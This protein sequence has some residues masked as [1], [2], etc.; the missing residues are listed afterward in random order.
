[1]ADRQRPGLLTL[2]L[3]ILLVGA[4]AYAGAFVGLS[5]NQGAFIYNPDRARTAPAAANL[6][7]FQAVE[8]RTP[9]GERLVGWWKPPSRPEEGV[10]LYLH[11]KGGHL[12]DRATRLRD[13]GTEGFGVLGVDWRGYGGSTG[14]PSEAGLNTDSLAAYD[15]IRGRL[16]GAKIAVFAESL[17]TGPAVTLATRRPVAGVVLDSA[18]ASILRLANWRLPIFPNSFL[19]TDVYRSEDRIAHIN[20]PLLMTHCDGDQTIPIAEARRLFAA[21]RPP[22]EM[23]VLKGC[24]HVQTWR[25]LPFRSKLNMRLHSWLDPAT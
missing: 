11:G 10:V 20:A 2:A 8:I 13:L 1:M 17:G 18:Y 22:K 21:A 9:D 6:A 5:L 24:G 19:M 16:P 12:A 3:E 15:W 23:V 25:R 14:E 7:Q 4:V